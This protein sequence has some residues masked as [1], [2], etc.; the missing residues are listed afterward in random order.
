MSLTSKK[1]F[2]PFLLIIIV[3]L[4]SYFAIDLY[5]HYTENTT[6]QAPGSG[7][8]M[9]QGKSISQTYF[10]L[11][12]GIIIF[13]LCVVIPIIYLLLSGNVKRQLEKNT[14]L[15]SEIINN[16]KKPKQEENTTSSKKL[17][18]KFLSYA[19][20]KVIKKLIENNGTVLQSEISRME[21]MGKVR[22][23]RIITEL[24]KKDIITVEPFGKTN[25]IALTDEAKNVLLK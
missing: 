23:H 4:F 21:S 13:I 25:R 11:I 17:F 22:T 16:N 9:G 24:K 1:W 7:Q 20:N 12:I 6:C 14:N 15:I 18:L 5:N 19:E 3:A 2:I 8:G 10:F